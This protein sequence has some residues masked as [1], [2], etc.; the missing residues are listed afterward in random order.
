VTPAMLLRRIIYILVVLSVVAATWF[1]MAYRRPQQ[2][3]AAA[4]TYYKQVPDFHLT[5]QNNKSVSLADLAGK[6][7]IAD[8]FFASCPGPCPAI[9]NRLSG[10][11]AEAFKDAGVRFVSISTDPQSDTP[12]VLKQYAG[13]FH[14]AGQWI[15][16]TGDKAQIFDLANRGFLLTAA[17]QPVAGDP[18]IHST[19]FALVD[20]TGNVRGYYDGNDTANTDQM[21]RDIKTLLK[22]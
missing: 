2:Q 9:S 12:E 13:R 21:L 20:K 14:A 8:F 15:F 17:D 16:L 22:E 18:V 10:L 3:A 7:W 19:K 1:Q 11:Q 5:D 4:L 6:V